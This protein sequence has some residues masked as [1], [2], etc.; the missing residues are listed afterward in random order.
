M[1]YIPENQETP[2]ITKDGRVYRRTYDSSDPVP[3]TSRYALD[4]LVERGRAASERFEGFSQD[5]RTFSQ[6]E[7]DGWL[8]IY[9]SP[10][11]WSTITRFDLLSAS[12]IADLL[13]SSKEP[14]QFSFGNSEITI[15]GNI[16]F[17]AAYPTASSVILRQTQIQNEAFNSLTLELD[18]HGRAKLFIP[19]QHLQFGVKEISN[20]QSSVVQQRLL[21]RISNTH[22][23]R[24]FDIGKTC[25][26][27]A[28][29]V[30]FYLKWLGAATT[31]THFQIALEV[32]GVWRFVPFY[33]FDSW[34]Y[35]VDQFGLPV[36]MHDKARIPAREEGRYIIDRESDLWLFLCGKVTLALGLP[37]EFSAEVFGQ[38]LA[39]ASGQKPST[40]K[41]DLP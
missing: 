25:L 39:A 24:L 3:E 30:N 2:F 13:A 33:D 1:P 27:I 23:L 31:L 29:L 35:H 11:P 22:L 4:Q 37:I 16:P 38:V 32:E 6:S 36:L 17:N 21:D 10:Y 40:D 7:K 26:I 9:I 18:V 5:N 19:L 20:L 34:G 15:S 12:T 8:K 28:C 14:V 41:T